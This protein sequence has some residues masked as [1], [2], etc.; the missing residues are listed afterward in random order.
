MMSGILVGVEPLCLC[1]YAIPVTIERGI[2]KL[3]PNAKIPSESRSAMLVLDPAFH[4]NDDLDSL[5][6]DFAMLQKN[7]SLEFL[8]S[9]PDIYSMDDVKP[10]N[11]N[12][13][14]VKR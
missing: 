6:F 2:V 13:Y 5:E 11:R 12:P 7:P 8:Q 3:P 14:F 4:S 1:M 10:E 9:E